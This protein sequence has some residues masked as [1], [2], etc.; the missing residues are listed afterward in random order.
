MNKTDDKTLKIN[1]QFFAEGGDESSTT[2]DEQPKDETPKVENE[3]VDTT[4][5][6][7]NA[8]FTQEDMNKLAAKIRREEKERYEKAKQDA[9][10][11][12]RKK[13]LEE[14]EQYKELLEDANKTIEELKREKSERQ[15]S[16]YIVDKLSEKKLTPEQIKRYSKYV[17]GQSEEELN[18]SIESVYQDFIQGTQE[19]KGDPSAGFGVTPAQPKAKTDEDYGRELFERLKR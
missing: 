7:T 13:E 8:Q 1:L 11:E 4:P 5:E 12:A 19:A 9:E 6:D 2:S 3:E 14:N 10:E 17:T 15:R 18:E 16:D